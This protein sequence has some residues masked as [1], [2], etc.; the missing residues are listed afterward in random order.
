MMVMTSVRAYG[1]AVLVLLL[2]AAASIGAIIFGPDWLVARTLNQ[3]A[4]PAQIKQI[5]PERYVDMVDNAR[6]T[7]AQAIAGVA[8][9]GTLW[10]TL[11]TIRFNQQGKISDRFAKALDHLGAVRTPADQIASEVRIGAV[12]ELELIGDESSRERQ[13]IKRSLAAYVRNYAWWG[14]RASGPA[15]WRL[16]EIQTMISTLGKWGIERGESDELRLDNVDL[17][18]LRLS[19]RA[20]LSNLGAVKCHFEYSELEGVTFRGGN[21]DRSVFSGARLQNADFRNA[22]LTGATFRAQAAGAEVWGWNNDEKKHSFNV[23]SPDA[24]LSGA[25]L[26][27]TDLTGALISDEQIASTRTDGQTILPNGSRRIG[28]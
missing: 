18:H 3:R 27:G 28:R 25:D 13:L 10:L 14:S 24:D 16:K 21:F 20:D 5:A 15:V 12:A 26:R 11:L 23:G 6:K 17:R 7:T 1:T 22:S 19:R 2:F 9:F 4:S 8:L